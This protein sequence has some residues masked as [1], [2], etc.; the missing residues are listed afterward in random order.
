M[1]FLGA[2]GSGAVP[3]PNVE[4]FIKLH[5]Q[6]TEW[7]WFDEP[8]T[9][10]VFLKLL[11]LVNWKEQKWRGI[12]VNAGSTI[13]SL[14]TLADL[15]GLSVRNWRTAIRN[16]E[17]TGEVTQSRHGKYRILTVKKW[18]EYQQAD[19]KVTG[20]RQEDDREVTA[21]EEGKKGRR[22]EVRTPVRHETQTLFNT[23]DTACQKYGL[24]NK[25]NIKALDV[26]VERYIRKIRLGVE[27]Q[28]CLAW[29]ID[30]G[31][32]DITSQ[33]VGNWFAK[34]LEI[35]GREQRRQDEWKT[36]QNDP[37]Q[38]TKMKQEDKERKKNS[39]SSVGEILANRFPPP[40]C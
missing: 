29:L 7:E 11:L 26:Y 6:I 22:K 21:I 15:S 10:Q 18:S 2:C 17:K 31:K 9:F 35:Q 25:V 39:T 30:N 20:K 24:N 28:K 33:R 32:R 12:T 8:T 1:L 14:E 40:S 23:I 5:R 3:T 19:T 34:A 4:G 27:F 13:K 38:K 37:L 16:L 36:A